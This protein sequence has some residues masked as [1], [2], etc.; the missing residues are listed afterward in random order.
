MA[1]ATACAFGRGPGDEKAL[2]VSTDGGFIVPHNGVVQD[3]KLVRLELE[4]PGYWLL[5]QC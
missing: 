2:Y 1:G 3:A 5:G 4:E